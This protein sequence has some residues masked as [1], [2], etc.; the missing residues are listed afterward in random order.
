LQGDYPNKS[1]YIRVELSPNVKEFNIAKLGAPKRIDR[2]PCPYSVSNS[3]SNAIF[4]YPVPEQ[5]PYNTY[6]V[7]H[8]YYKHCGYLTNLNAIRALSVP[9]GVSAS[10][11][12]WSDSKTYDQFDYD[13]LVPMYGGFD[14]KDPSTGYETD[15]THIMGFDITGGV[16]STGYA[17]YV[18]A[19]NMLKNT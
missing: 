19:L 2:I 6:S 8:P 16:N 4:N 7:L 13:F 18:K 9:Q 15:T 3:V 17:K 1:N 5:T 12:N 11:A 10:M 14:G